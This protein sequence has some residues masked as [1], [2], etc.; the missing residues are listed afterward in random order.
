MATALPW[1]EAARRWACASADPL[2]LR[3]WLAAPLAWD[4]YN[5]VTIEGV[6]ND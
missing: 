5:G 1:A 4:P 6:A 2:T 3:G